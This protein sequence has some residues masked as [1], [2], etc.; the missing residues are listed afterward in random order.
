M[1]T[2]MTTDRR[3]RRLEAEK[4]WISHISSEYDSSDVDE[5]SLNDDDIAHI[6]EW[7]E[8]DPRLRKPQSFYNCRQGLTNLPPSS[9]T[10][11][12]ASGSTTPPTD[13]VEVTI[14]NQRRV[15]VHPTV[16]GFFQTYNI[17]ADAIDDPLFENLMNALRRI[18]HETTT[19]P[20]PDNNR[21][22]FPAQ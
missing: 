19:S 11:S 4:S 20:P 9:Q 6:E 1:N 16:H 12:S 21:F 13:Y 5:E 15:R 2:R 14:S 10:T 22:E 7:D 17:P 18:T 8:N 3:L